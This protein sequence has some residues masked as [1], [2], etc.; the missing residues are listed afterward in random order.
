MLIGYAR[1][2]TRDQNLDLQLDKL[3]EAGCEKIYT[4]KASGVRDDRPGLAEAIAYARK[5]DMLTVWKLDRLGRTMKSL[6]RFVDELRES[7]VEFRSLNEGLD[8]ST[9]MGRF[10]FHI[11]G[12]LAQMEAEL[13]K[14]RTMAGLQASRARGRLG[15][16]PKKITPDQLVMART[17]MTNPNL[18]MEQIA[19]QLGVG[20]STL[21]RE[22]ARQ[23]V[24]DDNKN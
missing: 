21:Y 22:L 11:L 16:R 20:K 14:E 4:D 6:I 8:T 12:A 13:V 10:T 19:K 15:G 2:S 1:V 17:L 3:R 7:G 24:I 18:T 9:P 23:Q 5:G